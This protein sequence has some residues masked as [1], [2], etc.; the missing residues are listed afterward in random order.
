MG[1]TEPSAQA[2]F[3][4][5]ECLL[6]A[7]GHQSKLS[8]EMPPAENVQPAPSQAISKKRVPS[9]SAPVKVSMKAIVLDVP[10]VM[11]A[12]LVFELA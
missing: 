12:I 10:S 4:M 11:S 2:Q 3:T 9:G 8:D 6:D 1:R 7:A 5:P